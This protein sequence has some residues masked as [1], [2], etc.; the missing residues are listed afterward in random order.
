MKDSISPWAYFGL[1]LMFTWL[2]WIPAALIADQG[3][4]IRALHYAGGLMPT[5]VTLYVLFRRE[6]PAYRKDYWQRLTAFKRIGLPWYGVIFL[7]VPLLTGVGVLGD[8][9]LGGN[10]VDLTPAQTFLRSPLSLLPFAAF[11][12]LFGPLPEEMAWRGCGLDQSQRRWNALASSLLVG[13]VWTVWHL[14]LF[15]VD[16]SYQQGLG[17]GTGRFWLYM[18]QM[19]PLSVLMTW[20]FNHTRRS[21]ISAV[22]FH[23]MINFTGELMDLTF[24]AEAVTIASYWLMA[25]IVIFIWKP[26]YLAGEDPYRPEPA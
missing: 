13:L 26:K 1:A 8:L 22:L 18:M 16:G 25:F 11:L 20:I 21:T 14:P 15:W 6:K 23:F 10:G 24:R 3:G 2:F 9:L 4:P 19:L 7:T 5:L 17:V 12:L